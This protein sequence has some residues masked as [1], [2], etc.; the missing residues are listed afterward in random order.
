MPR[1]VAIVVIALAACDLYQ[2]QSNPPPD[3]GPVDA[4]VDATSERVPSVS[5]CGA[6]CEV[7]HSTCLGLGWRD[8]RNE[9]RADPSIMDACNGR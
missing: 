1:F 7:H 3:A 4:K 2:S 5:T 8:C 9:C 6:W